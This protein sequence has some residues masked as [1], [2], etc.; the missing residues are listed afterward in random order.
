MSR[1]RRKKAEPESSKLKTPKCPWCKKHQN[2]RRFDKHLIFCRNNH[3]FGK[4]P[5]SCHDY[6]PQHGKLGADARSEFEVFYVSFHARIQQIYSPT[7]GRA[8][9][10]RPKWMSIRH[11]NQLSIENDEQKFRWASLPGAYFK[12][13]PHPHSTNPTPSIIPLHTRPASI[14]RSNDL[15][16]QAN[17]PWSPF[18]TRADFRVAEIALLTGVNNEWGTGCSR[19]TIQNSDQMQQVLASARKYGVKF[20]PGSVFASYKGKRY[21]INFEYRDPWEWITTLLNDDTLGPTSIY[22]SVQKYY[23]EGSR[24][25]VHQERIIDEPYTADT[26]AEFEVNF[27]LPKPI[28]TLP[29]A[30]A[31]WLDD[32][33]V[34][35]RV[36]MKPMVFRPV[37][38]PSNIRNA[39]GNGGGVLG[40]Y[41]PPVCDPSDPTNRN[42]PQTL[43]FA[44]YK[45]EV[46]YSRLSK[47]RSWSGEPIRCP[48]NLVR[49][50]HPGILIESLDG[51]EASYFNACRAA[52][53]NFPCPKCLV[54]KSDLHRITREFT[55]RTTPTMKAVVVKAVR[56]T[57]KTEKENILK[58]YGL[59]GVQH[60][61]WNF[62]FSDPYAAYSYDTL[63]S[64]DL[65]KWGHHLWPL[66]LD[67]L[68]KLKQKGPFAENMRR[69][70]RWPDLKHFNQV[71]TVH[72]TDG[73]SFYDILKVSQNVF[74]R[75][76]CQL[77]PAKNSLV[78]CIRAYERYRIMVGMN[79]MPESRLQ[80]LDTFIEEYEYWCSR[81]SE[82]YG[83]DFDFF[84]QHASSHVVRDIRAK[85]TTNHG[86]TRPGEGFQQEAQEA[87]SHTNGK[88]A[89][90][91][92]S[93]FDETQEAIARIRMTIDN[94]DKSQHEAEEKD[95]ELDET[96]VDPQDT[97]HWAFGAP[98]R[99]FKCVH[100]SYQSLE[101]WRGA[102]DILRC[103][104]SF[105]HNV[106][107][108]CLLVN[109]T[110]PGL[111]CARLRAL[112]RCTLPSGRQID[113]ALVRMFQASRWKPRTLWAGCQIRDEAKEFSFLSMEHVIRGALLAPVSGAS[114]EP[115][116]FLIDTVDADMFLRADMYS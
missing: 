59:H 8:L 78:H 80:R 82:A 56:K 112:L 31:F 102:R 27:T 71:T 116:H 93:R 95:E 67:E 22:N 44:K 42:T 43:E 111:H 106:R 41:M 62:R 21:E 108:D 6:C 1:G 3:L 45:M 73:Q 17:I 25:V 38:Q 13:I 28:S 9:L 16:K 5:R 24:S 23:C 60:F 15:P 61:L 110:E 18:R 100:I 48:D 4:R 20:K 57:T 11:L 97:A 64:D 81:V 88:D 69:F 35:K 29:A 19:V 107:Y 39:S 7:N 55:L 104:P 36:S 77:F 58:S 85:G 34:T 49:V 113:I 109:L 53:A 96:P 83:K 98:M 52:L 70:P 76:L 30:V 65:G 47:T 54:H 10:R 89:A 79:C 68:E 90:H 26:W 40:G 72:F 84:K 91:Q 105:H 114:D 46:S 14:L 32:G 75:A 50:F 103:N 2:G 51:K 37:F 115:T 101:D 99:N 12:I 92:M 33:L 94:Y 87:Y 74:S 66:L 86:S 63:H